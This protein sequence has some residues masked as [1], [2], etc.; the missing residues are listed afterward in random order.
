METLKIRKI[1]RYGWV[2]DLPDHRDRLYGL[3]SRPSLVP[4]PPSVD[5]RPKCPPIQDQGDLGSCTAH[6]LAGAF[7]FVEG[8]PFKTASRLWIYFQERAIEGTIKS[9]GGAMLRDGIKAM[10]KLGVCEE[11]L[12]PYHPEK[13]ATKPT[14][15]CYKAAQAHQILAYARLHTLLPDMKQCLADGFPFVFGFTVYEGFQSPATSSTGVLR[16]PGPGEKEVGGHAVLAV[17]Y[18]D[19]SQSL[20][21]RNSWGTAWG[22]AGYFTMPYAYVQNGDLSDD[23]WTIR[24]EEGF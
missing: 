13:F 21:V 9:D 8:P 23:F 15:P 16:M 4:L 7:A 11:D 5:L 12:W 19:L 22:Q 14:A 1:Q 2:P 6:A 24:K 3:V 17:G 18:D 20:I 10:A